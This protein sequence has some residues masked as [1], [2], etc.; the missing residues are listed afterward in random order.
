M[1]KLSDIFKFS[2]KWSKLSIINVLN[3]YLDK[4]WIPDFTKIITKVDVYS[5]GMILPILFHNNDLLDRVEESEMLQNFFSLFSLMT[6]PLYIYRID[7]ENA[8]IL[9][10]GLIEKFKDIFKVEKEN[11]FGT[12]FHPEKSD[13]IGLKIIDNFISL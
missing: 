11:I 9:Y 3:N 4:G 7:I 8:Y 12:Q 13:K 6:V 1:Y 5:L 10:K 2:N